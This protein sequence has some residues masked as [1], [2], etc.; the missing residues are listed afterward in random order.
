MNIVYLLQYSI[1]YISIVYGSYLFF[2]LFSH[3]DLYQDKHAD[4][5]KSVQYAPRRTFKQTM[6]DRSDKKAEKQAKKDGTWVEPDPNAVNLSA[7]D[8]EA[9]AGEVEEE[10]EEIEVPQMGVAMTIGLLVVV[11]VVCS[12]FV[13]DF[14]DQEVDGI[15]SDSLLLLRLNG[16][17]ILLMV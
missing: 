1:T 7:V 17:L 4:V 10:E 5:A 3:K 11:T 9:Q 12:V 2:Q 6:A 14:I 15:V 8:T 13:S 16:S